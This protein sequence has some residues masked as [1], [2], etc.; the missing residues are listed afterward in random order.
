MN[1]LHLQLKN[2]K[3]IKAGLGRDEI[4]IDFA[5][6]IGELIAIAG[7]NGAGKTTVLDNM[8]P[9]RIMASRAT[10]YAPGSFSYYDQ[11][12][13]VAQKVLRWE[14]EGQIYESVI[15][16]K[17]ANKTKTQECY[18]HCVD[19]PTTWPARLPD[20]TTSDGKAATY[21]KLVEYI[22]GTPE[23]FFTAVFS[24]QGRKTLADYTNGDIKGLMSE[25]LSL[26]SILELSAEANDVVKSL[27]PHL[28]ALRSRTA[29]A[30]EIDATLQATHEA[31]G[32]NAKALAFEQSARTILD[33][34]LKRNNQRLAEAQSAAADAAATERRRDSLVIQI[35]TI[36]QR[37]DA[38][39]V[40]LKTDHAQRSVDAAASVR[41]T[42]TE[43]TRAAKARNDLLARI[44]ASADLAAAKPAAQD[45]AKRLDAITIELDAANLEHTQ[46]ECDVL[47]ARDAKAKYDAAGSDLRQLG[48]EGH[49]LKA[50]CAALV[51]R[52]G[53]TD[54]VP[55]KG[56][57]LQG[58][59]KLLAEANTAKA[60][61]P[62]K[63]NEL[64]A[65]REAREALVA[66]IAAMGYDPQTLVTAEA[67]IGAAKTRITALQNE[68]ATKTALAARL[69]DIEAAEVAMLADQASVP[70]FDDAFDD[71][72]RRLRAAQDR[73]AEI[74]AEI[75][76]REAVLVASF[77]EDRAAVQAE[78]D[79]LPPTDTAG[80]QAA[81]KA[82]ADAEAEL[83][84]TDARISELVAEDGRLSERITTLERERAAL[85]GDLD[86][87]ADIEND[88]AH[89]TL[90][91]K[92]LGPDGIVALCI[93]D[94]GPTLT[95]LA[96]DLLTECYGPRF[97][98]S[99]RTQRETQ[100]GTMK[101]VFDIIVYDAERGDEKSIRDVSGGERIW[102]TEAV[103]GAIA[104]Y[105]AEAS[106]RSYGCRFSDESDGALDIEKKRQFAAVKR[107]MQKRGGYKREFFISHSP[108][109]QET[110][111]AVI[112]MDSYKQAA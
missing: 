32:E 30:P 45:A 41:D 106:G 20:G 15:I 66:K 42:T 26:D 24:C 75:A 7:T 1:P 16:I 44:R 3:G 111:D 49:A 87:I 85:A 31:V 52:A 97:S 10:A 105:Q 88:I 38:A 65:K 27:R 22:L 23:M 25:L 58:Q 8:H 34:E 73:L 21:D 50:A 94:A 60:T 91:T 57:D 98:V 78:L 28:D 39:I 51:E 36:A 77:Q 17:G 110:A 76:E 74:G 112:W 14:H 103:T 92:A 4:S 101:E 53:L 47:N 83:A 40:Q 84:R 43:Q 11:T 81:Q 2:F 79:A 6:L 56:T 13:G 19:G 18:L 107:W 62:A 61:L 102:I 9:Y 72:T 64:Q 86:R 35:G 90:L 89:W 80:L 70:T 5:A 108:E 68:R 63:E 12:Y 33:G 46:A 104:L 37:A 55:C 93:D 109:V 48:T 82:V 71:A 67:A 59:C 29:R 99:I 54:D 95:A 69:A 100:A 96:N